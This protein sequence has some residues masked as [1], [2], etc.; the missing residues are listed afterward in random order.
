[1]VFATFFI[2]IFVSDGC[3]SAIINTISLFLSSSAEVLTQS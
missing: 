3:L 2:I 1:M